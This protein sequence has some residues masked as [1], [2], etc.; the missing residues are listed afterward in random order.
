MT[1]HDRI[2]RALKERLKGEVRFDYT[3][4]L[5]YSTD[6]SNYQFMPIGVVIPK[7]AEDVLHAVQTASEERIPI[8]PRG[9]GTS[10]AGQSVGESLIIDFSKYM[11]RIIELDSERKIARVQPGVRLL[12]LNQ[13]LKRYNLTLGPDPATQN[14]CNIGGM[15]ANNS[16]GS[17]SLVY[18]KTGDHVSGMKCIL[19]DG[20][21]VDFGPKTLEEIESLAKSCDRAGMI[22]SKVLE[23][24][25][26]HRDEIDERYPKIPRRVSGYNFDTVLAAE[27]FN[28][29]DLVTGSE[30]TLAIMTEAEVTLAHLPSKKGLAL[31]EFPDRFSALDSV[32]ALLQ[33][34]TRALEMIDYRLLEMARQSPEHKDKMSMV[35]HATQGVLILEFSC[36]EEDQIRSD[37]EALKKLSKDLPGSPK[38]L[39]VTDDAAQEAVWQ[40]REAGLGLLSRRVGEIKS[41]EFVEDTAI[42]PDRL[43]EY[44]RRAERIFAKNG[45]RSAIYGHAGQGCLHIRLD[46]T[47]KTAEGIAQMRA[48]AEEITDLVIEFGGVYSGEHGDGISRAE[49][50]PKLYGRS[51]MDL[52]RD[53]K[54]VFDPAGI[55]NPGKI[56]DPLPMDKNLKFGPDYAAKLP[57]TYFDFSAQKGFALAVESCNGEGTC[58]KVDSG[59]MCPSYMVTM[60]EMHSTR[61]RANA[62]REALKGNF[63]GMGDKRVL[64]VLDLCIACKGCKR[65]CPIGV[66]MAK[67]KAEY[68]AQYYDIHGI[69]AKTRAYGCIDS[70]AAM[71]SIAPWLA[72]WMTSGPFEGL[73]KRIAGV[74]PDRKLP[75]L[76]RRSFRKEFSRNHVKRT[77]KPH[78]ILLDDAFNSY[79][80]PET[81]MA[82]VEVLERA[83]FDVI[84]PPKPVSCARAF[85]SKGMLKHARSRQEHLVDILAPMVEQGMKIVGLEP[86]EV[87][88][89]RD[90]M[91]CLAKDRRANTVAE[92]A[93]TLEE[94]L[95]EYAK[96]YRPG[97]LEGHALVHGH[98][99]QKAITGVEPLKKILSRVDGLTFTI[100]DSGCCGMAGAFGYEKEHYEISRL[101]GERVLLPAVRSLPSEDYVVADGF[102]CRSQIAD[103]CSGRK[104]LHIAELLMMAKI[105]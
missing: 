57:A 17:H 77:D 12:Q 70:L 40:V 85:I 84:L 104:A 2:E 50:L 88:T 75:T 56:I 69:P 92:A 27:K 81:L 41:V 54:R 102:S 90:E 6:A 51:I 28:L 4:R 23:L 9:A 64:E 48:I 62:L 86:S 63:D 36:D 82:G 49:F 13:A 87:L 105:D 43:G 16:S 83:G 79:F 33:T 15:I 39:T 19:S 94:F 73:I 89:L 74:H 18:G 42:P 26:P 31:L 58:R 80:K 96:D 93:F 95:V 8:T 47:L 100:L 76:A 67:Y 37:M 55:M 46:M 78:V 1:T 68:L 65:E 71:G 98:C 99:H 59:V 97:R 3:S 21:V 11:D 25:T 45:T 22:A 52:H 32:P 7:D 61:A 103:F 24:I 29:A 72:N 53:V 66:D 35:D 14:R 44:V 60:E 101:I 38:C 5:L 10:L 30:G 91:P 34:N 20:T